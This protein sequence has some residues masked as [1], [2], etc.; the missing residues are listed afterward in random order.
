MGALGGA[1]SASFCPTEE[2]QQDV[3]HGLASLSSTEAP[4][5]GQSRG[6]LTRS[7]GA[8]HEASPAHMALAVG[9]Q[10]TSTALA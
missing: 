3:C 9:Q 2:N 5:L 10:G 4:T 1:T 8:E 7:T 6:V